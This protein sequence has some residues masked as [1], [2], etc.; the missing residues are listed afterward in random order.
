MASRSGFG[1][2]LKWLGGLPLLA[3]IAALAF[4]ALLTLGAA[5]SRVG[6]ARERL[7]DLYGRLF[8]AAASGA[9]PFHVVEIDRASVKK[10]GSWPWPR[11]LI[12]DLVEAADAAGAKGVLFVEGVDTPDP[13][14]PDTIGDFWLSAARDARLAQQ[15]ALLPSTDLMLARALSG[16]K[17]AV[18]IDAAAAPRN[19]A[20]LALERANAETAKSWLKATGGGDAYFGLPAARPRFPVDADLAASARVAVSALPADADGVTRAASLLWSVNGA[21]APLVALEAARIAMGVDTITLEADPTAV[22]AVGRTPQAIALGRAD[23]PLSSAAAMRLHFPRRLDTPTTPALKLLDKSVVNSQLAGKVVLIGL[24][25]SIGAS[26]RTARGDFSLA[27][28][29][30]IIARQIVA[31]AAPMRPAW[32]G[33]LE[34]G[35]VML[36]GAAAI[37]WSQRLAFWQAMGVALGASLLLFAGSMGVFAAA[38]ALIDPLPAS[39]ALFIGAFSVAGG[40]SIGAA[41]KDDSVRGR[42]QGALPEPTMKKLREEGSAEILGAV[43]RPV[44]VLACEARLLDE[45]LAKL[46]DAPGEVINII[47]AATTHLKKAITDSGGAFDQAEGGKLFAYFNAPT[48]NADH[49][50]AACSAALRIVESLDKINAEI[51]ASPHSLGA[52]L[53]LSIGIAT[54]DCFVGPMGHGRSNRYSAIGPAVEA[55]SFLARQAPYYGPAIICDESVHRKTNHHFAF[56]E[57]DRLRPRGTDRAFNVYALVGNTFIKSSKG[58]RALEDSQRELLAAYRRGD[59]LE[60]AASLGKARQS[61]GAKIALFDLYDERIRKYAADGAPKDWDGAEQVTI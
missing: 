42:F 43:R 9:S 60:A 25:R 19:A 29:Q 52:Q 8:P 18:A 53:H 5:E 32:F 7:F 3:V 33:Y 16:T 13:L 15:L 61:P 48:E 51:E 6:G 34:A 27:K 39:L 50:R 11:T 20:L 37:M 31:G 46:A 40:R 12:G 28:A 58:F 41:I 44:T 49:L 54:D 47:A 23:V 45:D 59:F 1:A 36:F 56:L 22:T 38:G 35:A 17:G 57:L 55:A 4:I 2:R 21:P 14:S 10:I 24:D 30:A 26:V